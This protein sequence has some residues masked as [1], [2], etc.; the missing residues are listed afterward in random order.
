[1]AGAAELERNLVGERTK[2]ALAHVKK[3]G[4]RLGGNALGWRRLPEL[5]GD[6]RHLVA[7]VDDERRTVARIVELREAGSSLSAIVQRLMAEGHAT[8]RGGRWTPETVRRVLVR[9]RPHAPR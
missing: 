9:E 3:E 4:V 7:D 1:M 8:K 5:D 6:G 2:T